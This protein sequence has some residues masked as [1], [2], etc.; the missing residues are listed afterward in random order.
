MCGVQSVATE[1]FIPHLATG[2]HTSAMWLQALDV[3]GTPH[4]LHIT[5]RTGI[6]TTYSIAGCRP[7]LFKYGLKQGDY[8]IF[9]RKKDGTCVVSGRRTHIPGVASGGNTVAEEVAH[10]HG[11]GDVQTRCRTRGGERGVLGGVRAK[12]T[13]P[14]CMSGDESVYNTCNESDTETCIEECSPPAAVPSTPDRS[15]QSAAG[16]APST[17]QRAVALAEAEEAAPETPLDTPSAFQ[18]MI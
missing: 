2:P 4:N 1:E 6:I 7:V 13:T 5:K 9:G 14:T 8:V 10:M 11:G 17:S 18:T 12:P 15:T 16:S 3:S